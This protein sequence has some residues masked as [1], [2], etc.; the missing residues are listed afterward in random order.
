VVVKHWHACCK[1]PAGLFLSTVQLRHTHTAWQ[2]SLLAPCQP[3]KR[4][5]TPPAPPRVRHPALHVTRVT[6][7]PHPP[8]HPHPGATKPLHP[9]VTT[10]P[11][12]H[13]TTLRHELA[14]GWCQPPEGVQAAANP[15]VHQQL[16][17]PPPAAVAPHEIKLLAAG[18]AAGGLR[19]GRHRGAEGSCSQL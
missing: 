17:L 5:T 9:C 7:P 18:A 3:A 2:C 19:G 4:S 14:A 16:L 15:T 1:N 11:P 6:Q 13:H 12:T 8:T 10:H